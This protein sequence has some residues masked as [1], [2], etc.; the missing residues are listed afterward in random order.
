MDYH[1]VLKEFVISLFLYG[2]IKNCCGR[3][4]IVDEPAVVVGVVVGVVVYNLFLVVFVLLD[5]LDVLSVHVLSVHVHV[6]P[7]PNCSK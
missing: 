3:T 1:V 6:S 7:P 4:E 2:I 5:V